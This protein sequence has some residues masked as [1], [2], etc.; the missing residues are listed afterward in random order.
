ML[1]QNQHVLQKRYHMRKQ[2]GDGNRQTAEITERVSCRG[3]GHRGG[4]GWRSASPDGANPESDF[5]TNR[6][7]PEGFG[8]NRFVHKCTQCRGDG[9]R[10]CTRDASD[11]FTNGANPEGVAGKRFPHKSSQ[12]GRFRRLVISTQL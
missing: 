8:G 2:R 1:V 11:L 5:Y 10:L 6:T 7:N 3:D 12:S 9:H 4:K